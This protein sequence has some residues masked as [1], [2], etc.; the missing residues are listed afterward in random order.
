LARFD[1][2][3]GVIYLQSAIYI[4]TV[5]AAWWLLCGTA[6]R[7]RVEKATLISL[8]MLLLLAFHPYML[9]NTHR[10]TDNAFN[11][12]FIVILASWCLQKFVLKSLERALLYGATLGLFTALRPNAAVFV[13]LPIISLFFA[14]AHDARRQTLR[15]LPIFGVIVAVVYG[16]SAFAATGT[17]FFW[18]ATGPYNFFAGNNAYSFNYLIENFNAEYS[19]GPALDALGLAPNVDLHLIEPRLY[20]QLGWR[21]ISYHVV[22]FI[23][24]CFTKLLVLFAPR[25]MHSQNWF[26]ILV[27]VLLSFPII[28]WTGCLIIAFRAGVR[29]DI[30]RRLIF[31]CLFLLPFILTNASP[32]YREPLDLWF[33]I[34]LALLSQMTAKR[35]LSGIGLTTPNCSLVRQAARGSGSRRDR[36]YD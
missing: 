18:P 3:P 26:D 9:L 17:P 36:G 19:I 33:L 34:D 30:I 8:A 7:G 12:L 20:V 29:D 22:G 4:A 13:V 6:G 24:L 1:G 11:P 32:H 31:V 10:I 21:F 27:Q 25:I 15:C 16:G 14:D 35:S 23:A 2:I 28:A 5:M